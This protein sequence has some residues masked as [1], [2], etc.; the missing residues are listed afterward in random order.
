[1]SAEIKKEIQLGQ[2]AVSLST[3]FEARVREEIVRPQR[4]MDEPTSVNLMKLHVGKQRR[5]ALKP[6]NLF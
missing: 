5:T 1:M 6:A 3:P 4:A 2:F